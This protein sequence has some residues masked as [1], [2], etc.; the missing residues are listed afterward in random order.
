MPNPLKRKK[1]R[2]FTGVH[3]REATKRDL[4]KLW[5]KQQVQKKVDSRAR[6]A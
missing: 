4:V 3:R 5:Q 6:P 2:P 1:L